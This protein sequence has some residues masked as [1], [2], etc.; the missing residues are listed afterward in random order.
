MTRI[1]ET[2]IKTKINNILLSEIK[3]H[4][5]SITFT[6]RHVPGF[7]PMNID[8]EP[9]PQKWGMYSPK[10]GMIVL[11]EDLYYKSN[12]YVVLGVLTHEIVHQLQHQLY[13]SSY[14]SDAPHG[15]TFQRIARSLH[16]DKF[17]MHASLDITREDATPPNPIGKNNG[18]YRE[19]PVLIKVRKL[20]ALSNSN[21]AHEAAAALAA[22]ERLL[23]KYNLELPEDNDPSSQFQRWRLYIGKRV[24]N[25]HSYI[26]HILKDSFFVECL[27]I[28]DYDPH[29]QTYVK[30]LEIMGKPVNL[31]MAEHVYHFLLERCET[32]WL[33]FKPKARAMGEK[34][35]GARQSF[36]INMLRSFM[37]KLEKERTAAQG[38]KDISQLRTDLI[39]ASNQALRSYMKE[40]YPHTRKVNHTHSSF[41]PNSAQAGR[42]EGAKLTIHSPVSGGKSGVQGRLES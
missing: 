9:L 25:K 23:L 27:T 13:P 26:A 8:F 19:H 21:E 10:R 28:S 24:E 39:L 4:Y 16:L 41:S 35:I 42:A 5:D 33:A 18:E 2:A 34:G 3:R 11:N 17:F 12:W 31:S 22:A 7:R 6:Y 29:T 1:P 36:I 32:L 20:L 37:E 15:N 40:S 14:A 38:D 30:Y